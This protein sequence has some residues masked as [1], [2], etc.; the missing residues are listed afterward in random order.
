MSYGMADTSKLLKVSRS[1]CYEPPHE[2]A[3]K[4]PGWVECEKCE[5]RTTVEISETWLA[6]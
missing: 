6:I 4:E 3:A 1:E 2:W 5:L